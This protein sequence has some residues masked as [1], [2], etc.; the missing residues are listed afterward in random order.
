[1]ATTSID[2]PN[3]GHDDIANAAAGAAFLAM[4]YD[5]YLYDDLYKGWS[6]N[7]AEPEAVEAL[8]RRQEQEKYHREL[9]QKFGQPVAMLRQ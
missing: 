6:D 4:S 5:G 7:P 8:V 2:H 1:M 3:G 9:M